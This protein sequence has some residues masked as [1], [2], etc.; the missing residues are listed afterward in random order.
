MCGFLCFCTSPSE[1]GFLF[2]LKDEEEWV[3][4]TLSSSPGGC[5]VLIFFLGFVTVVFV[6]GLSF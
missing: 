2:I 5:K 4:A 6:G 1:F 3:A